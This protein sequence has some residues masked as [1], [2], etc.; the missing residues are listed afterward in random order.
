MLCSHEEGDSRIF[1][2]ARDATLQCSKSIVIKANDTDVVVIAVAT[3]PS[4][5]DLGL[6]TMWIAFSQRASARWIPVHDIVSAIKS[7]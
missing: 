5:Q 7:I 3:L 1:V 4:L 2:H 6:Q